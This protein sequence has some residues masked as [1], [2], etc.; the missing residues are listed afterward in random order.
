MVL[1]Q[2]LAKIKCGH[3][4]ANFF[5]QPEEVVQSLFAEKSRL[6]FCFRWVGGKMI[7]T[8]DLSGE[9]KIKVGAEI[10]AIDGRGA[11]VILDKLMTIAR[12]DGSNDSKR[13]AD[14]EIRGDAKFEAFDI[15][16][17]LFFPS[18]RERFEL[19]VREP[20]RLEQTVDRRQEEERE[21]QQPAGH[22]QRADRRGLY[23]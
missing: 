7:V 4:Y 22:D 17:P 16:L 11:R 10:L 3:T 15:F 14:L 9:H 21:V 19:L 18:M 23:H 12:A 5:N 8:R 1:S 20:A 13:F 2:F 6:P